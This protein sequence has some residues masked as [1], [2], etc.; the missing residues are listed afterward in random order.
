MRRVG[1]RLPESPSSEEA[2][3]PQM[4][5]GG[6]TGGEIFLTGP[7]DVPPGTRLRVLIVS[8]PDYGDPETDG[9]EPAPTLTEEERRFWQSVLD[10][11]AA[12]ASSAR[13]AGTT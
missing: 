12:P 3:M 10:N 13:R 7:L 8:D 9:T 5:R 6:Y 1:E 11:Q 4:A 2:T